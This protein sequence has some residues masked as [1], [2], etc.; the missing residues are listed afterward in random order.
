MVPG[1]A[2]VHGYEVPGAM[3]DEYEPEP[4]A[5][6]DL[7]SRASER[8]E[9]TCLC[10]LLVVEK[11]HLRGGKAKPCRE[12]PNPVR[13]GLVGTG[14]RGEGRVVANRDDERCVPFVAALV[15]HRRHDVGPRR[16]PFLLDW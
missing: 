8:A 14:N 6:L 16:S 11:G 12:E 10:C 15:R 2:A 1:I 9:D 4:S 3:S 13:P 5:G 7:G